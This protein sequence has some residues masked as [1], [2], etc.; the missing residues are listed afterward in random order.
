MTKT[1][2]H[3]NQL[4]DGPRGPR[5]TD[6]WPELV[7][8]LMHRL[9]SASAASG[10]T[11]E[12]SGLNGMEGRVLGYFARH[13]G[14]TQ[15]ELAAHSG[16]DKAQLARL[17]KELRARGLLQGTED[18]ADRRQLR[19]APTAEGQQLL[20][21]ERKRRDA[22]RRQAESGLSAAERAQLCALLLKL[23]VALEARRTRGPAG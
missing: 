11:A 13:P 6:D 15:S 1:L 18:E 9:R 8:A 2:D 14:A 22:L 12:G 5:P 21:A 16:R 7:H 17:V 3:V 10:G 19:L 20:R 23:L 4:G